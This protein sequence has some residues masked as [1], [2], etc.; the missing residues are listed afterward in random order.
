MTKP[1]ISV[2]HLPVIHIYYLYMWRNGDGWSEQIRDRR[3]ERGR[4]RH[5]KETQHLCA[6]NIIKNNLKKNVLFF[7]S[8]A[9]LPPNCSVL[10][11]SQRFSKMLIMRAAN[12]KKPRSMNSSVKAIMLLKQMSGKNG[13]EEMADTPENSGEDDQVTAALRKAIAVRTTTTHTSRVTRQ[14]RQWVYISCTWISHI[15][16]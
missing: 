4:H 3:K 14:Q 11:D 6:P 9:P 1:K 15:K 16:L 13:S 12:R 10:L 2:S 8:I 5:S 7:F